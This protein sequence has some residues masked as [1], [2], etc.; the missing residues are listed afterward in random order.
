MQVLLWI[1]FIVLVMI[2]LAVDLGVF[3]K[4]ANSISSKE[5]LAWTAV[6]ITLAV[7]FGGFVYWLYET[8]WMNLLASDNELLYNGKEALLKY[9]TGYLIEKSLSLDNIFVMAMVF[10]F[11]RIPIKFQHEILFWGILGAMI[12]R[13]IMIF[14]GSA[15][16]AQFS[17][18]NYVFGLLL[19]PAGEAPQPRE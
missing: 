3:N 9:Y 6:W 19:L 11:F 4:K 5:A 14:A 13:G 2:F 18:V 1:G 10:A 7:I 12:F 8:N 17:W 16:I 15:L